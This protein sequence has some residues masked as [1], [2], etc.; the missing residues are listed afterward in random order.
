MYDEL[1]T[2]GKVMY[3][4][5]QVVAPG[6][7]L[8]IYGPHIREVS[9]AWGG[10]IERAGYHTRDYLMA[11]MDGLADIPRGVLAHL[12][13]VKGTGVCRGGVEEPDVNVVLATGISREVCERIN[14]GYMDPHS[15]RISDYMGREDEGILFVDQAGETLYRLDEG[16]GTA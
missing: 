15:V 7:T 12:T 8:I 16:R 11:R 6:G 9:R 13:H 3:K 5:E 2:A 14:L 1:W 10:F 4:L